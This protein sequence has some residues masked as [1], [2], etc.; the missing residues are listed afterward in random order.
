ML[1]QLFLITFISLVRFSYKIFLFL[2]NFSVHFF[3]FAC[4]VTKNTAFFIDFFSGK[5]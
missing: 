1:Q 4:L 2:Y 5:S 3:F